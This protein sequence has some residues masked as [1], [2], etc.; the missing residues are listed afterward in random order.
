[1]GP[2]HHTGRALPD[3]NL[4]GIGILAVFFFVDGGDPE[5]KQKPSVV[6]FWLFYV[7]Q[8]GWYVLLLSQNMMTQKKGQPCPSLVFF[9][10]A[11]CACFVSRAAGRDPCGSSGMLVF[12]FKTRR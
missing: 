10:C 3:P 1:M 5:N 11:F 2:I 6:V 4:I 12:F 7:D 8:A 9:F